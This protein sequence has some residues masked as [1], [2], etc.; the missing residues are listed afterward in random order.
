MFLN[1]VER[2]LSLLYRLAFEKS[3]MNALV[4]DIRNGETMPVGSC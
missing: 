2:V 4:S 1:L 3:L